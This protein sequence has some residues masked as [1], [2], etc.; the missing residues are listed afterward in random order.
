MPSLADGTAGKPSLA[1]G[2]IGKPS[3][4]DRAVTLPE[5]H[6]GR[7]GSMAADTARAGVTSTRAS[8]L[9][10]PVLGLVLVLVVAAIVPVSLLARQNPLENASNALLLGVPFG[11][12]GLIVA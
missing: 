2:A 6:G 9:A 4:A 12:V 5:R 10:V 8:R 11:G 1:D 7:F 3:P